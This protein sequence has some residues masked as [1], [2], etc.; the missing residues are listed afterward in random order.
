[1]ARAYSSSRV[2]VAF[3]TPPALFGLAPVRRPVFTVPPVRRLPCADSPARR[4]ILSCLPKK[5]P[6]EGHP[7]SAR[8]PCS[9]AL[10]PAAL[11]SLRCAPLRHPAPRICIKRAG[12]R[13]LPQGA[14]YG[15]RRSKQQVFR[16]RGITI[17]TAART[18]SAPAARARHAMAAG[19]ACRRCRNSLPPANGAD[20]LIA[21][22]LT[23]LPVVV[24]PSGEGFRGRQ[25]A[26]CLSGAQ[27]SEFSAAREKSRS[28]G[29][30]GPHSGPG[31]R[32]SGVFLGYFFARAKKYLAARSRVSAWQAA[33]RSHRKHPATNQAQS[34]RGRR[35]PDSSATTRGPAG[36]RIRGRP[37]PTA[38]APGGARAA[39]L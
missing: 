35:C 5:V 13:T 2:Y 36:A 15:R 8:E 9:R 1:M 33:D 32:Q 17:G 20:L 34:Q 10:G 12:P 18:P 14:P 6:K 21:V 19:R 37:R 39:P 16:P 4:E 22:V 26:G 31:S 28:E 7:D 3:G 24:A 30:P 23:C 25:G 11:N 38:D 27:R 29:N